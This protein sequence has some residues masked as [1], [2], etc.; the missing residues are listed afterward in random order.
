[1]KWYTN[2][3]TIE[4]KTEYTAPFVNMY[5][6]IVW[7]GDATWRQWLSPYSMHSL[8]HSIEYRQRFNRRFWGVTGSRQVL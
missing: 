1:M 4:D 7:Y 2:K 8:K 5:L 3:L 6:K